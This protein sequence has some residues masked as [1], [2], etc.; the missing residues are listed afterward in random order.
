VT[1]TPPNKITAPNAGGRPHFPIRTR[2]AA[3]VGE[4]WRWT[5]TIESI[6]A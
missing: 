2:W 5:K 1:H 3:R 6:R 4:F